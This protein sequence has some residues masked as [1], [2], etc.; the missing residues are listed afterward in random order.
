MNDQT[1]F[2]HV[3][4]HLDSHVVQLVEQRILKVVG[5]SSTCGTQLFSSQDCAV[6]THILL[7]TLYFCQLII[8]LLLRA[9][10]LC[11]VLL[12]G[13]VL[14]IKLRGNLI[15]VSGFCM[16]TLRRNVI[17]S[18]LSIKTNSIVAGTNCPSQR[19]VWLLKN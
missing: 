17:H 3:L 4:F 18:T 11:Q 9:L 6:L 12:Q 1:G 5:S 14:R 10:Q 13:G 7:Y 19:R 8:F 15:M 16:F 2:T